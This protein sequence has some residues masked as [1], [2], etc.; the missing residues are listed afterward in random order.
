MSV[1]ER[2]QCIVQCNA[3]ICWRGLSTGPVHALSLFLRTRTTGLFAPMYYVSYAAE[4]MTLMYGPC[5]CAPAFTLC[6]RISPLRSGIPWVWLDYGRASPRPASSPP[7]AATS[8]PTKAT[9]RRPRAIVHAQ[10]KASLCVRHRRSPWTPTSQ[11]IRVRRIHACGLR[12]LRKAHAE[13]ET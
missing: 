11:P 12:R 9:T 10:P 3:A 8:A 5:M 4:V 7:L 13:H 2:T 1:Y 6:L